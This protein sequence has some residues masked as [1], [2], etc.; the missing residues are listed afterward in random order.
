M[1]RTYKP[2]GKPRG[3]PKGT[4]GGLHLKKRPPQIVADILD[5]DLDD[6]LGG[7]RLADTDAIETKSVARDY[8]IIAADREVRPAVLPTEPA[9]TKPRPSHWWKPGQSGNPNGGR[10]HD[11][12]LKAVRKMTKDELAKTA[13]LVLDGDYDTLVALAND[14][15]ASVLTQMFASVCLRIIYKGDMAAFDAFLSRI[16]GKVKDEL[17]ANLTHSAARVVVTLPAN[18]R[19]AKSA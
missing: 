18:G 15:S 8:D 11:P 7:P 5:D 14:R 10:A 19:E 1:A 3:R 12:A 13:Q 2:T 6:L 17:D 16:I 4:G 9:A